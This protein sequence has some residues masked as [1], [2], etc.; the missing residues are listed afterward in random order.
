M[1]L[2]QGVKQDLEDFARYLKERQ[3]DK[4]LVN[5]PLDTPEKRIR[6]NE[7]FGLLNYC[8]LL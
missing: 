7:K 2:V 6:R 3:V 8:F 5:T 1:V 4:N